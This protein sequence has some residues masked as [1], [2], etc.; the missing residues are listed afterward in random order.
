MDILETHGTIS[1]PGRGEVEVTLDLYDPPRTDDVLPSGWTAIITSG[2]DL[3]LGEQGLLF[4]DAQDRLTA[5]PFVVAAIGDR[6]TRISAHES[7]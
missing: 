6:V 3:A 5:N 7:R 2:P 1:L 4:L